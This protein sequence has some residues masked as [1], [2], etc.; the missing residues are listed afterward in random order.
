MNA[1]LESLFSGG[2]V[3]ALAIG[4]LIVE[5]LLLPRFAP[6]LPRSAYLWN[7]LAGIGLLGALHAALAG[8]GLAAVAAFL[9]LGLVGHLG[10]LHARLRR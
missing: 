5:A 4:V 6:A 7:T 2:L 8:L 10:D 1:L 3:V 9:A